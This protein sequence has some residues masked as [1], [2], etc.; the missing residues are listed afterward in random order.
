[1]EFKEFKLA[2]QDHFNLMT[3]GIT[4]LFEVDADKDEL[5]R[6]YLD[7]FLQVLMTSIL[8]DVSMIVQLVSNSSDPLVM[9]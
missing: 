7:S 2:L 6:L 1:M 5:W 9:Q 3:Q 8:R 4:K